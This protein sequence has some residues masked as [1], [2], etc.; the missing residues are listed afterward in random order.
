[1]HLQGK[2]IDWWTVETEVNKAIVIFNK[3]VVKYSLDQGGCIIIL[4]RH[5]ITSDKF[6][7]KKNVV[8]LSVL[9]ITTFL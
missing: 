2:Q 1:M 7:N 3:K 5:T 6:D 8:T 9:R 4:S